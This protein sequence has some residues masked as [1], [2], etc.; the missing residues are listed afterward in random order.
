MDTGKVLID[1]LETSDVDIFVDV[2]Y[3]NIP[4]KVHA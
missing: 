2:T 3:K 1:D 4:Y